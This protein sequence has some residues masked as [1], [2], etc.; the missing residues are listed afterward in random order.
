MTAHGC[1]CPRLLWQCCP[2]PGCPALLQR[3]RS[4]LPTGA[5]RI[6]PH[7]Q[8]QKSSSPIHQA[9]NWTWQNHRKHFCIG[10]PHDR[11]KSPRCHYWGVTLQQLP[12]PLPTNGK[13][14]L[15]ARSSTV[16][17][18]THIEILR[19]GGLPCTEGPKPPLQHIPG[20]FTAPTTAKEFVEFFVHYFS[21][22]STSL[23]WAMLTAEAGKWN[24]G[25]GAKASQN[26]MFIVNVCRR[27][28]VSLT[29]WHKTNTKFL[30]KTNTVL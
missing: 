9:N 6:R 30:H 14:L 18:E 3:E 26:A 7:S 22:S 25:L 10:T 5:Q 23:L 21:P 2:M 19:F 28:A 12:I 24:V 20:R 29:F 8:P 11:P 1:L 27:K 13:P 16:R 17:R 15:V 4:C